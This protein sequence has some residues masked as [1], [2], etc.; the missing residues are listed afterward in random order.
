MVVVLASVTARAQFAQNSNTE[1]QFRST[2]TMTRSGS[3]LPNAAVTGITT[4]DESIAYAPARP[5]R[6]DVG[7]GSTTEDEDP[8]PEDPEEPFPVGDGVWM[9]MLLAAGYAAFVAY[10]RR[11]LYVVK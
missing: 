1:Y 2:S 5:L 8:D 7:G 9:L 6:R 3:T 10:R 11:V 4:A